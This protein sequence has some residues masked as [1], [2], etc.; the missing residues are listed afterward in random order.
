MRNYFLFLIILF[1]VQACNTATVFHEHEK[2]SG[3]WAVSDPVKF[4]FT[5]TDVST[6]YDLY[7]SVR[8]TRNYPYQNL[9]LQYQFDG[10]EAENTAGL[11]DLLLFE[12]KTGK[13][14]GSGLGDVYDSEHLIMA[15]KTFP[16]AG[17]YELRVIQFMRTDSLSGIQRI[18]LKVAKAAQ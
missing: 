15:N 12:R 13:P 2:V 11:V 4:S 6:P 14:I 8:N 1:F 7:I 16:A 10:G 17:T 3:K 9:F 18:G 5:V